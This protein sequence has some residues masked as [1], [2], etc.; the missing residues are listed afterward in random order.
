MLSAADWS[1]L[2]LTLELAFVSTALLV[3]ICTPLGWWLSRY[4]GAAKG[5]IEALLA[6]PLVLP[7]TVLGFYLL[8]AFSPDG[9]LGML[10]HSLNLPTLAFSFAGL[11]LGSVIYSLPFV[12]QPIQQAFSSIDQD[13]LDSASSLGIPPRPRFFRVGLPLAFPGYVTG[14]ALGFA[15]TLGE[16]GVVLMIGGNIPGETQVLSIRIYDQVAALNY[17]AAHQLSLILVGLSFVL[18]ALIY[19]FNP[20][21]WRQL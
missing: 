6:L 10:T 21:P 3:L 15:H 13:V 20:K 12:L 18:L 14:A 17:G 8:V 19:R 11:V 16:F 7:P 2:F 5:W 4:R 9:W 1:A